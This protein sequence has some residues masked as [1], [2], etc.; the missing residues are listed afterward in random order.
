MKKLTV[1]PQGERALLVIRQFDAPPAKV[2]RAL[3]ETALMRQWMT[4][5]YGALTS[6][7]GEATIGGQHHFIWQGEEGDLRVTAT[8]EALEPPHL[9]RH[10]EDWPDSEQ[11]NSTV[12]TRLSEAKGGTEMQMTIT[13]T[14]AE[15]RDQSLGFGMADGMEAMYANLDDVLQAEAA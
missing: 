10:R 14:S 12:E 13:F 11:M 2:W 3:T 4:T 6:L 9:I 1:T 7:E 8:Y 5:E 15:A